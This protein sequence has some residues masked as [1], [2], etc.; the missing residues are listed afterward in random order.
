M[1]KSKRLPRNADSAVPSLSSTVGSHGLK[2][3]LWLSQRDLHAMD[4]IEQQKRFGDELFESLIP[5]FPH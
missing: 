4:M 2:A 3:R 5:L 1:M